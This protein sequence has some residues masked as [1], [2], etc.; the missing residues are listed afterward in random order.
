MSGIFTTSSRTRLCIS[1][2]AVSNGATKAIW[3][4]LKSVFLPPNTNTSNLPAKVLFNHTR[5]PPV[6][7]VT[8]VML[9]GVATRTGIWVDDD[10]F[11]QMR[12]GR[13]G[14]RWSASLPATDLRGYGQPSDVKTRLPSSSSERVSSGPV[15]SKGPVTA[16]VSV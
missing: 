3:L 4:Q 13:P 11:V 15:S 16:S 5:L 7:S 1:P 2:V 6:A 9:V 10:T 12:P 14:S 8:M